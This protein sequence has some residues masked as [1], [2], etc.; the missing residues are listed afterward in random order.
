M[1]ILK[2]VDTKPGHAVL[3]Y[4]CG[5]GSYIVPLAELVGKEGAI[6]ALDINPAA[7]QIVKKIAV[8]SPLSKQDKISGCRAVWY[9][10]YL[11]S[12]ALTTIR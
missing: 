2:E 4:G 5:S 9:S 11:T 8:I 10:N 7:I 3:D 6:Y 12:T 1:D